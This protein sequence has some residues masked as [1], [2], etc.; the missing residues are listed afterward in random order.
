MDMIAIS[1]FVI[2]LGA[3]LAIA[4]YAYRRSKRTSEDYFVASRSI[5]PVVLFISMAATNFSAFTFFGFAG[6]AYKFGLAYYGIMA[7]GTGLMAL[8]F[9]FLGRQIWRLGKEHGYITPP[10]LIG[11]RFRSDSL[12]MIFLAVM[13]VFTLPYIATQAIG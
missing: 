13:V 3:M 5:G 10:E 1:F 6:A 7:F 12:R 2:Y 8:S 9:F 11:D 4:F